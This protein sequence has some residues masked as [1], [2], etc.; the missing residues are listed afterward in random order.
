VERHAF[1]KSK[2][3]TIQEALKELRSKPKWYFTP[4]DK[5]EDT[6]RTKHIL[7]AQRIEDGRCKPETIKTFF[8][9]FGYEV[10]V[11]MEVRK[12]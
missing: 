12:K 6:I 1:F 10:E 7:T 4:A 8:S 5:E 9:H 3:M 11:N 2:T